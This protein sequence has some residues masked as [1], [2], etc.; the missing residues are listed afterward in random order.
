MFVRSGH[1]RM[2][3]TSGVTKITNKVS[4]KSSVKD[5]Q[6]DWMNVGTDKIVSRISRLYERDTVE[7]NT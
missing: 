3:S 5:I 4:P 1:P 7:E 2:I 6:I